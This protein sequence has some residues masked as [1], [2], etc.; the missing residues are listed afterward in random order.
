MIFYL[1]THETSWLTRTE[2]PLFISHRRLRRRKGMPVALGRWALDSGGFTELSMY[3]EWRTTANEYVVAVRRYAD[4]IG[5]LAWCAPQDW[6]CEPFMLESTKKSVA[7]HQALTV[8]NFLTLRQ[9]LGDLVIPVLQGWT[10]DDYLRHADAYTAAGVDLGAE[11]T[12]GVGSVCRRQTAAPIR[13]LMTTLHAYGAALHGFG[14]RSEGL[15]LYHA[16]LAS[17]DSMAWSFNARKNPPLRGC[18]HARCSN[19]ILF[20]LA[21][22]DRLLRR[23]RTWQPELSLGPGDTTFGGT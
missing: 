12:V 23:C 5:G 8:E 19:C 6:M 1:G 13:R 2:V 15:E 7:E 11:R 21:W 17:A 18:S 3:G 14:V 22:R 20:A 4:E 16:L 9:E 10:P